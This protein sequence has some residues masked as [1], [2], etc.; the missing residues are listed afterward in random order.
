M[1]VLS[2]LGAAVAATALAASLAVVSLAGASGASASPVAA[3]DGKWGPQLTRACKRIPA[4][5]ER[6]EKLQTRFHADA[7]TKG[8]IAFLQARIDTAKTQGR[9][10]VAR[11]LTDRLATRKDVDAALPDVL[12]KLQDAK[13]VCDQRA[14]APSASS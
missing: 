8:S 3:D 7:H 5:I 6:V 13:S 14:A 4:R 1:S 9:T 10:D 12:A 2:G 11:L